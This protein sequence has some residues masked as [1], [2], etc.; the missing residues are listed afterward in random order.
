MFELEAATF[1][2]EHCNR[3][4]AAGLENPI[5]AQPTSTICSPPF[6]IAVTLA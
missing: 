1:E 6:E 2:S 5:D 3:F 4:P